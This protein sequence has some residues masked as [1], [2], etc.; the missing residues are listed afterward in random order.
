MF[1]LIQFRK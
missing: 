1:V